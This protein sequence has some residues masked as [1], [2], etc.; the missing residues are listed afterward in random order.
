MFVFNNYIK[1]VKHISPF[2][3]NLLVWKE[4]WRTLEKSD[5]VLLTAD[6]R[7]PLLYIPL[8]FVKYL[9]SVTIDLII[10]LTK[11]D[12]VSESFAKEW[13]TFITTALQCPVILNHGKSVR[14]K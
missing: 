6:V 10:I 13:E 9:K 5:V 8:G 3:H 4:L 14:S 2:E 1:K 7:D 12:L 11:C